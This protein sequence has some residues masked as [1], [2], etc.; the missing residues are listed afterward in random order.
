[1]YYGDAKESKEEMK[2]KAESKEVLVTL[3]T[4]SIAT[5][6]TNVK[7]WEVCFLVSSINNE[8][9]TEQAVGRIRRSKEGKI[10]TAICYDYM[11]PEAYTVSGHIYT[12]KRRYKKL[13]F[14]IKEDKP[15]G[16]IFFSKGRRK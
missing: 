13:H 9:N 7:Q 16:G 8:K 14:T 6:G 3:A 2:K 5:E 10:S 11:H 15:K 1:M 12:R 4:Y